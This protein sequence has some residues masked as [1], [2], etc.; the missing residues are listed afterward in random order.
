MQAGWC[1]TTLAGMRKFPF[2]E[3]EGNS[4]EL[5]PGAAAF[6]PAMQSAIAGAE[7]YI[8]IE[9]YL[10]GSGQ[11]ADRAI[12]LLCAA[13]ARGVIVCLLLDDFGSREVVDADRQRLLA[14]GVRI[15][16]YNPFRWYRW[17]RGLPRN[18]RKLILVD[19]TIAFTGGAGLTDD[20]LPGSP[21]CWFD[22]MVRMQ[23]PIVADWQALFVHTW[24]R[25][26]G[27]VALP[28]AAAAAAGQQSGRLLTSVRGRRK[29]LLYALRR[30]LFDSQS[31][32]DFVTAY[33]LPSRRM[34][35]LLKRA[36]RRGVAVRL[37]LPGP[38]NDHPAVYA[39][40][41]RYYAQLLRA[42]VRI[43]E[44]QPVFTHAKFVVADSYATLGSCNIDR[45]GLRW[46]LEAN[47]ESRDG[48]LAADLRLLFERMLSQCREITP[49]EWQRQPLMQRLR[50]WIFGRIDLLIERFGQYRGQ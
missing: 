35:R 37:L 11:L 5:L 27:M 14:A 50:Q 8:L 40:G 48:R 32:I 4:F 44:Y 42:G 38:I 17:L 2:P 34:L 21:D 24:Q 18:H 30:A 6:V 10:V 1:F 12:D 49:Q 7:R 20:Y 31:R 46:N 47:L 15:A 28:A 23:G 13:A 16:H 33:F 41:R 29:F 3:R 22:L 45:W 9:Q 26:G 43:F 25:W 39:A 36:A 19:G